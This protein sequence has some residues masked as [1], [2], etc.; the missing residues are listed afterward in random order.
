LDAFQ[1]EPRDK[2]DGY[3]QIAGIHGR[4]YLPWDGVI[5]SGVVDPTRGYCTH[6]SIL[7]PTWHRP[8]LALFEV[9]FAL[10]L[11]NLY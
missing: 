8:Y 2:L 9:N 5:G 10:L 3:F 6:G 4:P 1:K 7:F 11:K